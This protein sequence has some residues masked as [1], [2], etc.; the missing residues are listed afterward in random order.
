MIE[1]G[2]RKFLAGLSAAL[3]TPFL[4][5]I[6]LAVPERSPWEIVSSNIVRHF[7]QAPS[8]ITALPNSVSK[9]FF[10][11][12]HMAVE[13][14]RQ[15]IEFSQ[16]ENEF[17][18]MGQAEYYRHMDDPLNYPFEYHDPI[19]KSFEDLKPE[20][21]TRLFKTSIGFSEGWDRPIFG[22]PA[23]PEI[24]KILVF[25]FLAEWR[26]RKVFYRRCFHKEPDFAGCIPIVPYEGI[27]G[28]EYR[29]GFVKKYNAIINES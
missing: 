12:Y 27:I 10:S 24:E 22:I 2:R 18:E 3:A 9:S 21:T 25:E 29:M 8:E 28:G 11:L 20:T 6:A 16:T 15:F 14:N 5:K 23:K 4:S 1:T 13:L 7:E 26:R 19:F 17:E